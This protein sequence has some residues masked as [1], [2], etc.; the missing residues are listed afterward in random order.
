[1][2]ITNNNIENVLEDD[3]LPEY[4]FDFSKSHPNRFAKILKN[5]SNF[6]QLEPDIQKVF[7]NSDDVNNAL[8]AFINAIPK[9]KKKIL[10][11]V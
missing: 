10:Q 8:R 4:D 5:Q 1:M 11:K 3:L 9:K 6:I 7:K 2:K